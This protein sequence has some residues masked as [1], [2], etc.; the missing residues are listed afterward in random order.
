MAEPIPTSDGVAS[1]APASTTPDDYEHITANPEA[2]GGGVAQGLSALGAGAK[3]AADFYQHA[4][5][6]DASN[7]FQDFATKLLHG[8]PSKPMT[9]P[10]GMLVMGP[11]GKPMPDTGYLGT[12]GRTAMDQRQGAVWGPAGR[13]NAAR[14]NP[15][16]PAAA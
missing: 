8:D 5:S 15:R 12:R 3:T 1:V 16:S 11:D 6:D 4:A 2:F 7:Q 9:G 14:S 10:D 13:E